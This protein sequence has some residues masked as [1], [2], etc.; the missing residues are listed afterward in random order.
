[1]L[2]V[3]TRLLSLLPVLFGTSLVS[4]F[5]IRLVPGDPALALLGPGSAAMPP[6][7]R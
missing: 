2:V 3:L 1:M 6:L 4:F 5:L 7:P